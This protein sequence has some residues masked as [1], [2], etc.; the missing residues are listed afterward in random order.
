MTN[1]QNLGINNMMFR[2][3]MKHADK[4]LLVDAHCE[5]DHM[6]KD[7]VDSMFEPQEIL[8]HCYECGQ[9]TRKVITHPC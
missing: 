2:T 9:M 5:F 1:K 7:F 3:L 4:T 8:A 6:V